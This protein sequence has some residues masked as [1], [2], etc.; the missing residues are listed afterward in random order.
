MYSTMALMWVCK[1]FVACVGFHDAAYMAVSSAY[2]AVCVLVMVEMSLMY[3]QKSVGR[4]MEPC[5]TPALMV[6]L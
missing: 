2:M 3:I 6:C 4:R 5:G 1:Y